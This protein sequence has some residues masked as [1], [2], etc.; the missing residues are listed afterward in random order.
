MTV[1]KSSETGASRAAPAARD[2]AP[3]LELSGVSKH[4][5]G[6]VALDGV[7]FDLRYGEVHVLFGENG[8]GKST[9]INIIAGTYPPDA[10]ELQ[11]PGRDR[12]SSDARIRRASSASARCSRNSVS[13]PISPCEQNLFLGREMTRGGFLHRPAMRARAQEI[14][15]E[16]GFDLDPDLQGRANCRAPT[17]RW[18]RSP[19]RFSPTSVCSSSTSRRRR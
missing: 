15:R 13:F 4:F 6:V 2:D 17:S 8:A 10:G 12:R 7:D 5:P 3:L 9:L 1:A 14:I 18:W 11:V 16:L 19:R